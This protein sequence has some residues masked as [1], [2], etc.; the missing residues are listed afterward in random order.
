MCLD[1]YANGNKKMLNLLI[2]E[3]LKDYTDADHPL[4]QQEIIDLLNRNY[5]MICDRRSVRN[6]IRSLQD[7][8]YDICTQRGCYLVGREFDDAELRMLIDSV[9]F[10]KNLSCPQAKRLIDKLKSFGNRY[11]HAKVTHV[12]NLPDI[13]HS[14]NK[15]TMLAL[16]VLNDAIEANRK[17]SFIYN[18]YGM[19]FKLHPRRKEPYV[20]SPYQMVANNGRY[21]LIGNYDKYD[22]VSHYRIDRITSV[23]VLSESRKPK[24][25]I[26]DFARG[27]NLPR[28][29][30]EHIYMYSGE[31]VTVK[32]TAE[33]NLM[34]ELVDW[35]GTDFRIHEMGHDTMMVT[36]TC[37]ERAMMYWALQYGQHIEIKEP[38]S[39]RDSVRRIVQQMAGKYEI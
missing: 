21:Y 39:L 20:V 10:S 29:M 30:A 16:D 18:C 13:F 35:F 11:F 15:Q 9:L 23:T 24:S 12:S 27:F 31:S 2:L 38:Q 33:M 3:I 6:N 5:G 36:L 19:D 7:M 22:D 8:G 14:D 4:T 25:K 34:D 28:H 32:F 37:N 1:L 17:V 26:K